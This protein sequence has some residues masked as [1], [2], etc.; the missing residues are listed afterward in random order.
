MLRNV[1]Q[2]GHNSKY[3]NTTGTYHVSNPEKFLGNYEPIYKS[4]L[5]AKMMYYLDHSPGVVKWNYEA[6]PIKYIDESS[7][8]RKV[9]NYF[10]DFVAVVKSGDR[11]QTV[12]IEVKSESETKPPGK[13]ASKN[14]MAVQTW[15]K[16]QSKW[17][18]ARQLAESRGYKFVVISEKELENG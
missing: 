14:P 5:E 17:K 15:L 11:L 4:K 10:I 6:F 18:A 12:W 13:R 9:R 16:N 3:N 7:N 2:S 8:E 1:N